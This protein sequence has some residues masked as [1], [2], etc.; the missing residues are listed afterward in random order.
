MA[1]V[2]TWTY[3]T[4]HG[5]PYLCVTRLQA[6]NGDKSYPQSRWEDGAWKSGKP[7]GPKIPYRLPELLKA[8]VSA[9][10]FICE[11]EKC[12][13]AVAKHGLVATSASEGAGKWTADL[14]SW[15]VGRTV[16]ILPDHDDPGRRHAEQVAGHLHGVAADVRIV[17]LPGLAD[18]EDVWDWLDRGNIAENL[19]Y[20]GQEA[21]A[22][23]PAVDDAPPIA[24]EFEQGATTA[25]GVSLED[26][27]AYMP[28]HSYIYAPTREMWPASSV[29]AQILSV[30]GAQKASAWLDQH[31]PIVQMTWAP[32]MPMLIRDRLIAEGGWIERNGVTCFNLYR[33]PTINPG[34]PSAANRGSITFAKFSVMTP[35]T[36]S[37]G[38]PTGS[39]ARS[40]RSIMHLYWAAIRVSARIPCWNR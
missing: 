27:H 17:P 26:F 32:G 36:L 4:A 8:D 9:P 11:G 29:N 19:V 7:R 6:P 12:A 3:Y 35:N 13:E 38:S 33:P 31:K 1:R 16:Y 20:L 10:V 5:E 30:S 25:S 14:N 34:D 39:S 28:T 15:F 24:P 23:K 21:P 22:W 40:R 18:G 37:N 2:G